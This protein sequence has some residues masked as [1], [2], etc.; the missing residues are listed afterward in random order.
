MRHER[1]ELDERAGI[2]QQL[3]SLARCQ[4]AGRVLSFDPDRAAAEQCFDSHLVESVESFF[5]GRHGGAT[6]SFLPN[7]SAS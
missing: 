4:L 1:V 6:S 5:V 7:Q 2:Q 3:E